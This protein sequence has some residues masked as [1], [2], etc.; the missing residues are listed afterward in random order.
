MDLFWTIVRLIVAVVAAVVLFVT[1][2]FVAGPNGV[3]AI[4]RTG[5]IVDAIALAVLVAIIWSLWRDG[6]TLG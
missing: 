6:A 5:A 3:T 2:L 4:D 1:E